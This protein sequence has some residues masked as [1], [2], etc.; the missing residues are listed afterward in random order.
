MKADLLTYP[1]PVETGVKR[2]GLKELVDSAL[3]SDINIIG[4]IGYTDVDDNPDKRFKSFYEDR[5]T[6]PENYEFVAHPWNEDDERVIA[7]SVINKKDGRKITFVYGQNGPV[8][9]KEKKGNLL[10][11]G[12]RYFAKPDISLEEAIYEAEKNGA[13]SIV[14]SFSAERA[15]E[16]TGLKFNAVYWDA[17]KINRKKQEEVM[18][19]VECVR[20]PVVPVSNAHMPYFFEPTKN[21]L[22]EIGRAYI[23]F[24]DFPWKSG[25]ELVRKLKDIIVDRD[26]DEHREYSSLRKIFEWKWRIA[27]R[28]FLKSLGVGSLDYTWKEGDPIVRLGDQSS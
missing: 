27:A 13:I 9:F 19:E 7:F 15:I 3:D 23:E 20:L 24:R 17:Q 26:F 28:K 8:K 10:R 6:L 1:L 22:E 12:T 14:D 4:V 18:K 21:K 25:F 11:I 2:F 5:K 16:L